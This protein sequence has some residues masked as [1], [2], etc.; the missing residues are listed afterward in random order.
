MRMVIV[1]GMR[2]R[3]NAP[4]RAA[5]DLASESLTANPRRVRSEGITQNGKLIL[6]A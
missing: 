5:P 1:C 2:N 6:T 3:P 4:D